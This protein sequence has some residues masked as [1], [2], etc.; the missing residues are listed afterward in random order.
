M[1]GFPENRFR[2]D[3]ALFLNTELRTWL[4]EFPAH[5]I[6]FG[7]TLFADVGR[8]F[9]NGTSLN[10][11]FSDLKYVFGFG[12]NSSFFNENFIFRGDV[13]FSEEGYGIYFTAGYMF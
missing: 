10:S 9:P 12:G 11:V 7:G 1:R 5:D 3:N 8:T 2:D 13:G 4:F 6:K